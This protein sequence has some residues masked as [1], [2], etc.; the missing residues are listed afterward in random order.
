[1]YT[2]CAKAFDRVDHCLLLE[3]LGCLGLSKNAVA[4]IQSYLSG[5]RNVVKVGG[6]RS[7]VFEATSGVPQGSNLGPLLF[8]IFINDLPDGVRSS[9][10][11]LY[12]D[13]FK[14]FRTVNDKSDCSKLQADLDAVLDWFN[15]NHMTLNIEKCSVVTFTRKLEFVAESYYVGETLLNRKTEVVDL[16]VTFHQNLKFNNHY[17]NITSKAYK[18]LGFV[19]RNSRHFQIS[20]IIALYNACVR[21]YVEYASI[22]WMP[23][24]SVNIDLIERVQKRFLRF[25]Y[26][27]KNN[28]YPHMVSYRSMLDT[29]NVTSLNDRRD[30][31]A[32]MFVYYIINNIKYNNCELISRIY[33]KVPKLHLRL[34]QSDL[35]TDRNT[36]S[37]ISKL[38]SVCNR[39]TKTSNFDI[40]AIKERPLKRLLGH[41]HML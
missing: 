7:E 1:V 3:K 31:Q 4:F 22:I 28:A 25:L 17:H 34:L 12:A 35:F 41:R 13:D 11:L 18:A 26:V 32:V 20:T 10:C 30:T 5:R 15:M 36:L 2:D 8:L 27:K 33:L 39:I 40:F 24:A 38:L 9:K 19:L 16:G 14:M 21:P 37:P 29:F 6:A 23:T